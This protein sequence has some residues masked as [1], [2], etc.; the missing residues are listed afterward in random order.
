MAEKQVGLKMMRSNP[1]GK[2]TYCE[3]CKCSR[4]TTCGCLKSSDK[5]RK[6]KIE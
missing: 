6:K 4:Y 2:L 3:N 1:N 5:K